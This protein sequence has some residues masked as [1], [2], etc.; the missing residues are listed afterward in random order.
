M[1]SEESQV[2]I[3]NIVEDLNINGLN[4]MTDLNFD[5][6]SFEINRVKQR[7]SVLM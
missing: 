3:L 7:N 5:L 2:E 1:G 4:L 6:I